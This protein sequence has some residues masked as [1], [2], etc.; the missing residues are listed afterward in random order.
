MG[1]GSTSSAELDAEA[2]VDEREV[3]YILVHALL[4]GP[5]PHIG[6]QL[7]REAAERNL[8]PVRYD[9]QGNRHTPSLEELGRRHAHLPAEFLTH[10]LSTLHGLSRMRVPALTSSGITSLLDRPPL[11]LLPPG[12]PSPAPPRAAAFHLLDH[13]R[14]RQWAR[15]ERDPALGLRLLARET[16]ESRAAQD[17]R[18]AEAS[19]LTP[20]A[21]RRFKTLRGH[22]SAVYCTAF[23]A[24]GRVLASGADDCLV[25]LWSTTTCLLQASCRGHTGEI[26]DL[27]V[28]RDDTLL[29]SGSMDSTVVV[30]SLQDYPDH[31]VLTAA[32]SPCGHRLFIG[33]QDC[34][35][36]CWSQAPHVEAGEPETCEALPP[37]FHPSDTVEVQRGAVHLIAFSHRG[38][39]IAIGTKAGHVEVWRVN[40]R[41]SRKVRNGE[42]TR[43]H[44][45]SLPCTEEQSRQDERRGLPGLAVNQ[46]AW[47]SDDTWLLAASSRRIVSAHSIGSRGNTPHFRHFPPLQPKAGEDV[48]SHSGAIHVLEAH[49]SEPS[50]FLS[51]CYGGDAMLWRLDGGGTPFLCFSSLMSRP[52]ALQWEAALPYIEGRFA[53]DGESFCLADACGQVH[54]FSTYRRL[55]QGILPRVPEDQFFT[56]DYRQLALTEDRQVVDA[57]LNRPFHELAL[58]R[59]LCDAS[60]VNYDE[61][62]QDAFREGRLSAMPE[63]QWQK[64]SHSQSASYAYVA[65]PTL[66]AGWLVQQRGGQETE[67]ADAMARVGASLEAYYVSCPDLLREMV[68]PKYH[69]DLWDV[70]PPSEDEERL[71]GEEDARQRVAADGNII[72]HRVVGIS[73]VIDEDLGYTACDVRLRL[74]ASPYRSD[75]EDPSQ[76]HQP[77]PYEG[78][79]MTVRLPHPDR[80]MEEFVILARDFGR[81]LSQHLAI[82]DTVVV[83]GDMGSCGRGFWREAVEEEEDAQGALAGARTP[84]RDHTEPRGQYWKGIVVD[85][86]DH[87][88]Y[89]HNHPSPLEPFHLRDTLLYNSVRVTWEDGQGGSGVNLEDTGLE[90]GEANT[91]RSCFWELDTWEDFVGERRLRD[92]QALVVDAERHRALKDLLPGSR[93]SRAASDELMELPGQDVQFVSVRGTAEFY[94]RVVR[95]GGCTELVSWDPGA[96]NLAPRLAGS[97]S[98][99][100]LTKLRN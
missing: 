71:R 29:A 4:H 17:P 19:C 11:S 65:P 42:W 74:D 51:A 85:F 38:D 8:L 82:G 56:T 20:W 16:G 44:Q 57:A 48:P 10:A 47:N 39:R 27:A 7:A 54:L 68:R 84:S 91:T 83:R 25:K 6:E 76:P 59:V 45:I 37:S 81:S 23:D 64:L 52:G 32:F 66:A 96:S 75:T 28:S 63:A 92:R 14:R 13:R 77:P 72:V 21:F 46:F 12:L 34:T 62:I 3:M 61:R 89:M 41:R 90:E 88:P 33:S 26:T 22:Q 2:E 97:G 73:Y 43:E 9:F 100:T 18:A 70:D 86:D 58:E 50:I 69:L 94:N 78:E 24:G 5:L 98:Q 30:W 99:S 53:P 36:S 60:N 49:P 87:R 93:G 67:T 79:E 55:D 31:A 1:S 80:D 15:G 35:A 95:L 40:D